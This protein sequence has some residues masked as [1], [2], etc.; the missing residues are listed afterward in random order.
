M[1]DDCIVIIVFSASFLWHVLVAL[2]LFLFL[3]QLADAEFWYVK[4]LSIFVGLSSL[5]AGLS[6]FSDWI[7]ALGQLN[8]ALRSRCGFI[9]VGFC[10]AIQ[11]GGYAVKTGS[12]RRILPLVIRLIGQTTLKQIGCR[13]W[14][15]H[16]RGSKRSRHAWPRL[17]SLYHFKVHYPW[18]FA[19]LLNAALLLPAVPTPFPKSLFCI[20]R[21][22]IH[23][24]CQRHF[25][26]SN[27]QI[28][29]TYQRWFHSWT[30]LLRPLWSGVLMRLQRKDSLQRSCG[31]KLAFT[32]PVV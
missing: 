19:R 30:R 25:N 3:D 32:S 15:C 26:I 20:S 7:V 6:L 13:C 12:L 8:G 14:R 18:L 17:I 11:F 29:C 5:V 4:L 27:S 22:L 9:H 2:L 21:F 10:N 31:G 24:C 28:H 23:N 1:S 16:L